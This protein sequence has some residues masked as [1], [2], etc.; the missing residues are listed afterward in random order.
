ME[1]LTSESSISF[2]GALF[3]DS[4]EV[5]LTNCS[6]TDNTTRYAPDGGRLD[7]TRIAV[8]EKTTIRP[9]WMSPLGKNG[10]VMIDS[11]WERTLST[12]QRLNL[13]RPYLEAKG[14]NTLNCPLLQ[15]PCSTHEEGQDHPTT[16]NMIVIDSSQTSQL[17]QA[18][19]EQLVIVADGFVG[20]GV[21]ASSTDVVSQCQ[22]GINSTSFSES[23]INLD[24]I[25]V[26]DCAFIGQLSAILLSRN[27]SSCTTTLSIF[28]I[29]CPRSI[30]PSLMRSHIVQPSKHTW[31]RLWAETAPSHRSSLTHPRSDEMNVNQNST[32]LTQL[33]G[34]EACHS[35]YM[36]SVR[37]I[38]DVL[39]P[40]VLAGEGAHHQ[41]DRN[42]DTQ[43]YMSG[44][45]A[46]GVTSSP[47]RP[48]AL[49]KSSFIR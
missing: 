25:S 12:S 33:Y 10:G 41:H 13:S 20:Q 4:S 18:C 9:T 7:S 24:T 28:P 14:A 48:L 26:T 44:C 15:L 16:T 42:E 2:F 27:T 8:D 45:L 21:I 17:Q 23:S 32:T 6:F 11:T 37:D 40:E 47:T 5:S 19:L 29:R 43:L 34:R 3:I 30:L 39:C 31:S 22:E 36:C 1:G 35:I 38:E 49:A 46:E